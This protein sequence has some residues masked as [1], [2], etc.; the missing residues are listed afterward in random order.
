MYGRAVRLWETETLSLKGANKISQITVEAVIWKDPESGPLA[1]LREP[2]MLERQ[3][4]SGNSPWAHTCWQKTFLGARYTTKRLISTR[5]ILES[6]SCPVSIGSLFTHQ[7]VGNNPGT[8]QAKQPASGNPALPTSRSR[9][10]PPGGQ[11]QP[12]NPLGPTASHQEPA[13]FTGGP[14][15]KLDPAQASPDPPA[16]PVGTQPHLIRDSTRGRTQ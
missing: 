3:E 4:A 13:L 16:S 5:A 11:H 6:S 1:D 9:T 15:P 14:V 8:T 10:W 2:P 12:Q 7:L